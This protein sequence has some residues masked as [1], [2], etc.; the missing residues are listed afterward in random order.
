MTASEGFRRKEEVC[1]IVF[2]PS[3]D[4]DKKEVE[5]IGF[6]EMNDMCVDFDDCVFGFREKI[7][8]N[9]NVNEDSGIDEFIASIDIRN[10]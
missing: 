10:G 5:L 9:G 1:H 4:A 8:R 3:V 7:G 2:D 6:C